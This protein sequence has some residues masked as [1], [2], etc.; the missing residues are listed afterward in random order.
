[1]QMKQAVT[2]PGCNDGIHILRLMNLGP[3]TMQLTKADS[4]GPRHRFT[5]IHE[6]QAAIT[7]YKYIN[8]EGSGQ[9]GGRR[10]FQTKLRQAKR[11]VHA[12]E[13]LVW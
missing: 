6:A 3:R 4:R 9:R 7:K 12:A 8:N 2:V 11:P 13:L 1:M 5:Q 10:C